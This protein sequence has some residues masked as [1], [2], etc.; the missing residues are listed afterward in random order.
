MTLRSFTI[1]LVLFT[2]SRLAVA[3]EAV[4]PAEAIQDNSFLVEEAYNQEPGVVQHIL[5]IQHAR[6]GGD[7]RE[8]EFAFTQE[9]PFFSQ[10]HQLSYTVP[11]G[12]LEEGGR[13]SSGIGDISLNYR[14]QALMENGSTPAFAPR[15][16][17]I[18]PTSEEARSPAI[19]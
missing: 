8:W 10:A 13:T 17:L 6:N 14:F 1:L 5:T 9:W 15:V 3:Q 18:L 16:S 2:S 12:V 19:K 4:R 11:F 7:E